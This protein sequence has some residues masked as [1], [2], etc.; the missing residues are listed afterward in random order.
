[1]L[2]ISQT[3]TYGNFHIILTCKLEDCKWLKIHFHA[4]ITLFCQKHVMAC[5]F[6]ELHKYV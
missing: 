4:I 6:E 2:S 5:R 1:M 3:Y